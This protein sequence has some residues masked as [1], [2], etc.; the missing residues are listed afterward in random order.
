MAGD[1]EI[2]EAVVAVIA[3]D[4]TDLVSHVAVRAR[5]AQVL[6]AACSDPPTLQRLKSMRGQQLRLEVT[7]AGDVL[8]EKT[9]DAAAVAAT[10]GVRHF[11][12]AVKPP[13]VTRFA[14][15]MDEF[16]EKIVGQKS[17]NQARLRGRLPD[18]IHQPPAVALPFGVFEK[19][20]SLDENKQAARHYAEL[21]RGLEN[22]QPDAGALAKLREAVQRLSAPEELPAA[23]RETFQRA[24]LSW[25]ENWDSAW[26]CIKQVWASKWNERAVFS[27][28]K[29]GLAHQG[30][31]MAVLIQPVIEAEYAFVLHTTNPSTGNR[32][33]LYGELVSGLGETLVGNHPGRALSFIWDKN[34]A[35]PA[36]LSFPGK[37][38][39]WFGG[40]LIFR[41]DSNGE[42]LAGFAGAGLYDSVFLP[43]PRRTCLDYS[44]EP[45]VW[46]GNFRNQLLASIAR[47]GLAVESALGSP[48]DIEGAVARG[49]YF[50]VQTRPQAGAGHA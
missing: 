36:L 31:F 9:G 48:Q 14:V 24:G 11:L 34:T 46:D 41:S 25:P 49:K 19:V 21:A 35:Q 39:G 44:E 4:V 43:P 47:L 23:L 6:F 7:A 29:T 30:L 15:T 50:L 10:P 38:V 18:W 40:G 45:L 5:N 3:P 2:P 8:F 1:E 22:D 17:C 32:G 42:D 16:D 26:R 33:E 27:R 12:P 37:S 20:L 28:N 13:K